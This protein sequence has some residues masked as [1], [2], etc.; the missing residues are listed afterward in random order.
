MKRPHLIFDNFQA[1]REMTKSLIAQGRRDIAFLKFSNAFLLRSV[2]DRLLGYRRAMEEAGLPERV[3]SF[4]ATDPLAPEHCEALERFL[5]LQPRPMALITPEDAYAHAS[6]AWLNQQGVAVPGDVEVVGFDN[7][8]DEPGWGQFPTTQPDFVRMGERAAEMLLERIDSRNFEATEV[9]LPCP[10]LR[11]AA[12][13]LKLA[14]WAARAGV[15]PLS[16]LSSSVGRAS[17][18]SGGVH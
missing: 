14:Q 1:G 12:A 9:V 10:L 16:S 18:T 6:I 3:L 4:E 8:Q 7:L 2:D 13:S 5:A 11:P 15:V 17:I